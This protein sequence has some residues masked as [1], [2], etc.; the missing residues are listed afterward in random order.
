MFCID[1]QS[2]FGFR[3]AFPPYL[4]HPCASELHFTYFQKAFEAALDLIS[5]GSKPAHILNMTMNSDSMVSVEIIGLEL[6]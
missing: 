5:G 4:D 6:S 1:L 2:N 3:P